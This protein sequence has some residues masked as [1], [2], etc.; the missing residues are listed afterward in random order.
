MKTRHEAFAEL[1][2]TMHRLRAPGGCPWDAEQ[3]HASLRP[4]LVEEAYEVLDAIEG[5]SDAELCEEL[6]DL[7][8]QV[9]FH[10]ELAAERE[11][12]TIDDVAGAITA[13]LV[14]RHPHVFA[15]VELGSSADVASN[16]TRIKAAERAAKAGDRPASTL[17]GVPR[18]LP[19][20]L[21]A[22]RIGERAAGVG[23]DWPDAAGARAKIDEELAE[24]DAAVA[25]GREDD[26]AHELGD[27]LFALVSH[28]RLLG[29]NAEN[30]LRSCL[31]RFG[32]RFQGVERE[33]SDSG[34]DLDGA[35]LAELEAAW[36]RAK[37][38]RS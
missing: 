23:F 36:Q 19:A 15:D 38:A 17:D 30:T 2:D 34:R 25:A 9:V 18:A 10:A 26:V 20:L 27:V 5:G 22:H 24:L 28:A 32:E 29:H 8:L 33:F 16:W 3:T 1:V 14:R 31:E 37:R 4:Y 21:R 35:S 6:G 11:S 13:K 12:F 7:L